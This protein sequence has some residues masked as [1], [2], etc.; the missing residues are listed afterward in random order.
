M[1]PTNTR[2]PR[3]MAVGEMYPETRAI[4][5]EFYRPHNEQLLRMFPDVDFVGANGA[6]SPAVWRYPWLGS[7]KINLRFSILCILY[8]VN[9]VHV[10]LVSFVR[11][12][13]LLKVKHNFNFKKETADLH[14]GL[15]VGAVHTFSQLPSLNF[16]LQWCFVLIYLKDDCCILWI[17]WLCDIL[18]YC[19]CGHL[20]LKMYSL[21]A[22]YGG[23]Y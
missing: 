21:N 14:N 11:L 7:N 23:D 6:S 9:L 10:C 3:E 1:R 20:V 5:H 22:L 12:F 2:S 16:V 18:F 8:T 17:H 4:L 15:L 19:M 13:G